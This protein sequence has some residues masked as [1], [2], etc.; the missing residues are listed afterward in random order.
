MGNDRTDNDIK[1][2]VI[3]SLYWDTRVDAADV[4]VT[5]REGRVTLTGGV[6]TFRARR[7]AREDAELIRGVIGVDNRVEVV[8]TAKLDTPA[9][10]DLLEAVRDVLADDP[11]L[12]AAEVDV[13][14]VRGRV[15]LI[16][17]VTTYNERQLADAIVSTLPGVRGLHNALAVVPT[18]DHVDAD[19]AVDLMA[20]LRRN[21]H[22]DPSDVDVAVVRGEVSLTGQVS[23]ERIRQEVLDTVR[24]TAGVITICDDIYVVTRD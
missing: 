12:S 20:A 5:V 10:T 2:D 21:R 23:D 24:R 6:P 15:T 14:V 19:I 11:D 9:D 17:T 8:I 13:E 16:G 4:G 1:R 7:A 18:R 22:L 3:E